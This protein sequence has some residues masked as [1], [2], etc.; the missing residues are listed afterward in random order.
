[1]PRRLLRRDRC[2]Y[3]PRGDRSMAE[4]DRSISVQIF[5]VNFETCFQIPDA[6]SI[7]SLL[8]DMVA[9]GQSKD[10]TGKQEDTSRQSLHSRTIE[11]RTVRYRR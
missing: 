6:L 8:V 3:V 7:D 1:M 2:N 11:S 10:K 4:F 5:S 9:S